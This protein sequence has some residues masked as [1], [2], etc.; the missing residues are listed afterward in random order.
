MNNTFHI[1][2]NNVFKTKNNS[3]IQSSSCIDVSFEFSFD[4]CHTTYWQYRY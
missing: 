3:E 1:H 4:M 2:N